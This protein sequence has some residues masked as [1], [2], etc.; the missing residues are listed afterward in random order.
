MRFQI[1]HIKRYTYSDPIFLE[2]Q[3]IRM[4]P[5]SDWRQTCHEYSLALSP[6]PAGCARNLDAEGNQVEEVWFNG[7]TSN[8]TITARSLVEIGPQ[9]PYDYILPAYAGKVP[10]EYPT[11]ERAVLAPYLNTTDLPDPVIEMAQQCAR[12]A[13]SNTLMFASRLSDHIYHTIKYIHRPE[14]DPYLPEETID[15]K[16]GA[17]RDVA[18]LYIACARAMGMAARFVTGYHDP[19]ER[20]PELHAWAEVYI[21]GGGWR[22][23]DP[24]TGL[25][26]GDHHIT[27]AAA[28]DSENA[29]TLHGSTR[30]KASH[31]LET[32]VKINILSAEE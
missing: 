32:D 23:F 29:F 27:L 30:R 1:E 19:E 31:E 5:R 13:E 10:F 2:P 22:G 25:A 7:L 16:E 28:A 17:C 4:C 15:R 18:V 9:N 26:I 24:S 3:T 6:D 11:V 20:E 12:E 14:G 8:L 21:P